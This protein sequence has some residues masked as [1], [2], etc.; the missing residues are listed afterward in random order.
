MSFI[1]FYFL[2][3]LLRAFCVFLCLRVSHKSP[4]LVIVNSLNRSSSPSSTA[5]DPL[6]RIAT[7]LSELSNKRTSLIV[8]GEKTYRRSVT[9]WRFKR[10]NSRDWNKRMCE[11]KGRGIGRERKGVPGLPF[12]DHL[13][14]SHSTATRWLYLIH[15]L[16]GEP[17]HLT[18]FPWFDA[19][20]GLIP[21][22]LQRLANPALSHCHDSTVISDEI[23]DS[24]L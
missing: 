1:I 5:P 19:L 10:V 20:G 9:V 15:R 17:A 24:S 8:K 4:V 16:G 11:K 6:T 14:N 2:F 18:P 22:Y 21:Y 13:S 7:V 23:D 12:L 3:C